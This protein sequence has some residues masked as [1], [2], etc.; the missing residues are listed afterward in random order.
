MKISNV[1]DQTPFNNE[2]IRLDREIGVEQIS[3]PEDIAGTSTDK[4]IKQ[5]NRNE[6]TNIEHFNLSPR[7]RNIKYSRGKAI[8][9]KFSLEPTMMIPKVDNSNDSRFDKLKL[10]FL[11]NKKKNIKNAGTA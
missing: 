5:Q 6:I 8:K 2:K 9:I 11:V 1:L 3:E 7:E 4:P 10:N